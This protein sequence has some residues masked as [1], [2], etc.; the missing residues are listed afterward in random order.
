M[1]K[2][3]KIAALTFI[4]DYL[5]SDY[6][7]ALRKRDKKLA[8]MRTEVYVRHLKALQSVLVEDYGLVAQFPEFKSAAERK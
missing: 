6:K 2:D 8:A 3:D 4:Y 1:E 5:Y 7:S